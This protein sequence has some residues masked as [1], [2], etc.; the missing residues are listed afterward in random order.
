MA[1]GLPLEGV[2]HDRLCLSRE[3]P[4]RF[5]SCHLPFLPTGF[6][7]FSRIPQLAKRIKMFFALAPVASA[8][9]SPSPLVKLGKFPEFLLKVL[10]LPSPPSC[11]TNFFFRPEELAFRGRVC[12]FSSLKAS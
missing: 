3:S 5:N 12:A 2:S 7:A 4:T 9:F 10:G 8:K 6:I 11:P 1:L